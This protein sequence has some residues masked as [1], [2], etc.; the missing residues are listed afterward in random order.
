MKIFDSYTANFLK[1]SHSEDLL[2]EASRT[3]Q[4]H[5]TLCYGLSCFTEL[6]CYDPSV[7]VTN[8]SQHVE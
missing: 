5:F 6:S 7:H 1:T 4:L 8:S 3:S 2:A